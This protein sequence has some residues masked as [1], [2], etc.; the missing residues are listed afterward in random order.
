MVLQRAHGRDRKAA[1][2]TMSILEVIILAVVQGVTEF[3][4]VS[5][6]GHLVL[7]AWILGADDPGVAFDVAVHL[8]TL[9][10]LVV[11]FRA[12]AWALLAGL[13][14]RRSLGAGSAGG[15]GLPPSRL[16][17]LVVVATLPLAVVGLAVRDALDGPLRDPTWVGAFLIGTGVMLGAADRFG[18]RTRALATIGA[19]DGLRIGVAQAVAVLPGVSRSGVCMAAGMLHDVTREGS[20]LFALYLAAPAIGGAGLWAAYQLA[21]DGAEAGVGV[22]EMA[23]GAAVSFV[24][25][26]VAIRGLLAL[27]RAHSLRVF[28]VYCLGAGVAVLAARAAGL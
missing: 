25:A 23:L 19:R 16:L 9:L 10:A 5:S 1:R 14:G 11:V 13:A 24:V 18:R 3:L 4:P 12:E 27:V 6:S 26:V 22:G 20:A 21:T 15:S 2:R 17:T 7:G 8:G 28:V